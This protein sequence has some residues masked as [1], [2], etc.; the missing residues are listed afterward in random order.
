M[1]G[2]QYSAFYCCGVKQILANMRIFALTTK[3]YDYDN[4]LEYSRE[5]KPTCC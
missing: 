1:A 4:Q 2:D 5:I 3:L